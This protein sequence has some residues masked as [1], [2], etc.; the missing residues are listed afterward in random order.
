M[1]L[2]APIIALLICVIFD[3]ITPA[4][5]F[6]TAVSAIWFGA[7]NAAREIV[8]ENEIYKRERMFNLEI[9][10]YILSKIT[11]LSFFAIIQSFFFIIIIWLKFN[12]PDLD[13]DLDVSLNNPIS[14]F[15]WMSFLSIASTF[16][17]LFL[18]SYFKTTEK[19]K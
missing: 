2:Q 17:G 19:F 10:P 13:V 12:E 7:N 6:I 1:L 18:S 9:F 11:V 8:A 5:T 14:M 15:L 16:L 3:E 4:V